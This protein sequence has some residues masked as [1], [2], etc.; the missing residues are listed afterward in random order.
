MWKSG[1]K[2]SCFFLLPL[3]LSYVLGLQRKR[4]NLDEKMVFIKNQS[5]EQ[6]PGRASQMT[7]LC[8]KSLRA[9]IQLISREAPENT[10]SSHAADNAVSNV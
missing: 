6:Y 10:P 5:G 7:G 2:N 8:V 9:N 4:A 3:R 1:I